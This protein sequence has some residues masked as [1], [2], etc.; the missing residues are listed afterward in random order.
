MD[1]HQF[2]IIKHFVKELVLKREKTRYEKQNK[3]NKDKRKL[4][5]WMFYMV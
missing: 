5:R 2:V 4:V 1:K 3:T